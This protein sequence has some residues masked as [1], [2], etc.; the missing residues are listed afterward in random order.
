MSWFKVAGSRFQI[1]NIILVL[2]CFI[3]VLVGCQKKESAVQKDVIPVKVERIKL[4]EMFETLDYVGDIKAQEEALIYPKVSG[5]VIEKLKEEGS[6][7]LKDEPIAFI[8]RDEVGLKFEKAPVESTLT[9]VVGR[10]YV[11][12]GT[13]VNTQTPVALVVDMRNI[14]IDLNIPEKYLPRIL[15]D[16]NAKIYVD[17]YPDQ[18][19]IG[20]VTKISPVVDLS[21][22]TAPI[23]ITSNNS[24]SK[25]KSGMFCRVNLV[26]GTK[27]S[28]PVILK[29]AIMGKDS[30]VYVFV[31]ENNKALLKAVTLGLRQGPFYEVKSG[32]NEGDLIVVLGQQ[33]LYEG[34]QVSIEETN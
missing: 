7:V 16:Q 33:R 32:L 19:F 18:A 9:G 12:I 29:E 3:F 11:D 25:L 24:D 23:E 31:I 5:K 21:T 1:K 14:Q 27:K 30:N 22:R 34:A 10:V 6:L 20:K 17:A 8:D 28:V 13:N 4:Q 26:V 15:L 2:V